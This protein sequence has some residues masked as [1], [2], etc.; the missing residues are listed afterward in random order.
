MIFNLGSINADHFYRVTEFPKPGE[1]LSALSYSKGLGGKGANQ[2]VAIAKAGSKVCHIGRIGVDGAWLRDT[3]E[4]FGVD[5]THTETDPNHP[6]GHAIITI[7]QTSE[8]QI[9]LHPGAN[10]QISETQIETAF[11]DVGSDDWLVAQNETNLVTFAAAMM[12][13]KGGKVAYSPAPFVADMCLEVLPFVD[14]LAVNE[15]EASALTKS[16]GVSDAGGLN[17]PTVVM[18]KG[19]QGGTVF[20]NG[21]Q[22]EFT[23]KSVNA[24]DTTAAGD[25]FFGYFVSALANGDNI[26]S[27][28]DLANTAAALKVT[29]FGTADAIPTVSEVTAFRP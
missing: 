23:G 7:D 5:M 25:T 6:T 12:K 15:G 22:I 29:R 21:T 17:V 1:T 4:S 18:T 3:M 20:H 11:R 10:H 27:A 2:S 28:I 26:Q 19:S 24:K 14:I 8:N 16:M 13:E 9:V